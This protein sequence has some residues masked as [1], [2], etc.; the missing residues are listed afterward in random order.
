M[1]IV[2]ESLE[3]TYGREDI[4]GEDLTPELTALA[5]EG[6]GVYGHAAGFPHGLDNGWA[7]RRLMLGSR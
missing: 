1:L 6:L 2:A 4:F 7:D 3:A 5:T